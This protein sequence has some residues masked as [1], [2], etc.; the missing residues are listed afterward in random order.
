MDVPSGQWTLNGRGKSVNDLENR[1]GGDVTVGSNPTPSADQ[2]SEAGPVPV[3]IVRGP[4]RY[5]TRK[6]WSGAALVPGHRDGPLFPV[7]SRSFWH[8]SGTV[9]N[10]STGARFLLHRARSTDSRRSSLV[11]APRAN[12]CLRCCRRLQPQVAL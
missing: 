3:K 9:R 11:T 2:S 5:P 10:V 4:A 12:R 7:V 8:V 1:R 6:S